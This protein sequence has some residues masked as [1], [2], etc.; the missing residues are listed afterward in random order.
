MAFSFLKSGRVKKK[1]ISKFGEFAFFLLTNGI[2]KV[3]NL[4]KI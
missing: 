2:A 1:S 4:K 3:S